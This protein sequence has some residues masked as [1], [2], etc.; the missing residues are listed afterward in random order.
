M[1]TKTVEYS[2]PS[3][4]NAD[5][6]GFKNGCWCVELI[7]DNGY[8]KAIKGFESEKEAVDYAVNMPEPWSA[9]W[10]HVQRNFRGDRV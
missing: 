3:S 7:P 8:P 4:T 2:Y 1:I 5:R 9:C 10:L 6:F